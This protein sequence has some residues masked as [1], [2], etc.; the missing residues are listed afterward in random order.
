MTAKGK[1]NINGFRLNETRVLVTDDRFGGEASPEA[2]AGTLPP[3]TLLYP[4]AR[5]TRVLTATVTNAAPCGG[6]RRMRWSVTTD[7]GDL[8]GTY[9][10]QQTFWLAPASAAGA[11]GPTAAQDTASGTFALQ[12][13]DNGGTTWR[14]VVTGMTG[15][16]VAVHRDRTPDGEGVTWRVVPEVDDAP[17]PAADDVWACADTA[18][19]DDPVCAEQGFCGCCAVTGQLPSRTR[20]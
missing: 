2:L 6:S 19:C 10:T 15:D 1:V 3:G 16:D 9:A 14:M 5:K 13:S 20:P 12:H 4:A 11:T 8:A 7:R 17:T 18:I